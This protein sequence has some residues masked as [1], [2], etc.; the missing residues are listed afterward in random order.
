MLVLVVLTLIA[1]PFVVHITLTLLASH[2]AMTL[3]LLTDARK[4]RRVENECEEMARTNAS[5][6][7][8]VERKECGGGGFECD[9]HEARGLAPR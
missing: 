5:S 8:T 1:M 7:A 9:F 2:I 3:P 6:Y 4:A